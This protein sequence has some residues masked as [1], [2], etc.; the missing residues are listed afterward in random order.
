[1]DEDLKMSIEE[2]MTNFYK[3]LYHQEKLRREEEERKREEEQRKREEEQRKR[4][5]EQRKR[6]EEQRKREEEQRKREEEQ[7][8]REEEQRRREEAESR[9]ADEIKKRSISSADN[10]SGKY[11]LYFSNKQSRG[12]GLEAADANADSAIKIYKDMG[13]RIRGDANAAKFIGLLWD[14]FKAASDA[15]VFNA[16]CVPSGTGKS[17]LA[18]AL[19]KDHCACI[20]FNMCLEKEDVPNR[21]PIYRGFTGYMVRF[22]EW[23]EADCGGTWIESLRIYG[24]LKALIKL[25]IRNPEI[26]LPADL[27]KLGISEQPP[28]NLDYEVITFALKVEVCSEMDKWTSLQNPDRLRR[29]VF[30]IDEFSPTKRLTQEHLAYF[31][32]KLMDIGACVI[33]ASTDSG[34][35]NML[36]TNAATDVSRGQDTPWVNLCT[37]LPSYVPSPRV[38]GELDRCNNHAIKTILNLCLRSRPLFAATVDDMI[39]TYL[40]E[41]NSTNYQ[42]EPL[43]ELFEKMRND[44]VRV[45]RYKKS[46]GLSTGCFGYVVAMLLAGGALISG[47]ASQTELFGNLST[48]NWAY[49]VNN[50]EIL[51]ARKPATITEAKRQRLKIPKSRHPPLVTPHPSEDRFMRLSCNYERPSFLTLFRETGKMDEKD[52]L[53]FIDSNNDKHLF[54][55]IT[56][57]PDPTEDFLF[58]LVLTGSNAQP[59]L[60]VLDEKRIPQR[61]SV[62]KL[63]QKALNHRQ[64]ISISSKNDLVPSFANHEAIV[65]AAFYTAC[66]AGSLSGCSLEELVTRFVAELIIPPGNTLYP[67]LTIVDP[68]RWNGHFRANFLFPFDA[69]MPLEV[70]EVLKTTAQASRPAKEESVDAVTF[71][72]TRSKKRTYSVLVEAKSTT[73]PRYVKGRIKQALQ[74]QDTDAKICFIVVDKNPDKDIKFNPDEFQA[75]NRERKRGRTWEKS[76][77]LNARVF[78]VHVDESYKV[79]LRPI[80]GKPMKALLADR[81]IFVICL[82]EINRHFKTQANQ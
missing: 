38:L 23:L 53:H 52:I 37:Q 31:R 28:I 74:R 36:N 15:N 35:I 44:L 70:Y 43:I 9:L 75:L 58:Y 39:H 77:F 56:F 51:N 67:N 30:F 16:L 79:V 40:F 2:D 80:D 34:A 69:R 72:P 13:D 27:S 45:I 76:G 11:H 10:F 41:N 32:R 6:E 19:P 59:G 55:C 65:C 5:E 21:Q 24:F 66:N 61:I 78:R 82:E 71:V 73:K 81:L 62:A 47:D 63:V 7:R 42:A 8:K 4:E 33:V 54:S 60:V 20:Y 57:F 50:I 1:M 18:F 68:I 25:L 3:R 29:L 48:Q 12:S 26:D 46:A 22:I 17:Q 14:G 49:L 64:N